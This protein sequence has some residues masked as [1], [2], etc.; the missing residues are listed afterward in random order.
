MMKRK[1]NAFELSEP[2][3]DEENRGRQI[4]FQISPAIICLH[5]CV[6]VIYCDVSLCLVALDSFKNKCDI[7]KNQSLHARHLF[8]NNGYQGERQNRYGCEFL[9]L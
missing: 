1:Q 4:G 5:P 7:D 3:R 2:L 6:L 8:F 9:P